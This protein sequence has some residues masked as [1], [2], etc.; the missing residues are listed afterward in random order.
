[1]HFLAHSPNRMYSSIHKRDAI[2]A[3]MDRTDSMDDLNSA[4][5][6][7]PVT[8]EEKLDRVMACRAVVKMESWI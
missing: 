6:S 8:D 2:V 5:N 3:K 4:T 1:M 7:L